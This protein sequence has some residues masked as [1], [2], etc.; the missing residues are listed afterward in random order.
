MLKVLI[1]TCLKKIKISS[2]LNLNCHSKNLD[3]QLIKMRHIEPQLFET[4]LKLISKHKLF[5]LFPSLIIVNNSQH[6]TLDLHMTGNVN[7]SRVMDEREPYLLGALQVANHRAFPKNLGKH[8][9]LQ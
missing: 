8:L 5:C 1:F 7:T 6:E 3:V 2:V 9:R 4:W